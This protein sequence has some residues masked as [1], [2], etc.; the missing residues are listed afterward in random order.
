MAAITPKQMKKAVWLTGITLFL[1]LG[2]FWQLSQATISNPAVQTVT[3]LGTGATTNYTI[4]FPF[5]S[6]DQIR[7][8]LQDESSSPPVRT[9]LAYGS[10]AAKF[11][12]S[13]G[14]PGTTVVMGTAPSTSQRVVITRHTDISQKVHYDPDAAFPSSD[15][16]TNMDKAY[17]IL[18]EED[19]AIGKKVGLST[20]SSATTP[21][22]PDPTADR[23]VMYNHAGT[24]LQLGPSAAAPSAGDVM[25]YA[26]TGWSTTSII[27]TLDSSLSAHI[28]NLN[29]PHQVTAA[30]VGNTSAQWNANKIQGTTVDASGIGD[31]KAL[32]YSSSSGTIVYTTIPGVTGTANYVGAYNSAGSYTPEAQV[33][34]GQGG[35]GTDI[36]SSTGL[37][38]FSSGVL[39]IGTGQVSNSD[40]ASGAAIARSKVATGTAS[41]VV[42]NDG[43]GALSSEASLAASRGGLGTPI[44]GSSTGLVKFTSGAA[45]VATLVD[46]DVASGASVGYTKLNLTG[47]IT[48]SDIN[49]GAAIARSKIVGGT[50][51][52]IVANNTNGALSENAALSA[53]TVVTADS[54][55]QLTGVAPGTSG[56]VLTSTGS[57]W[58]S[59][60]P[61][62]TSIPTR[63]YEISNLGLTA[64][65]SGGAMTVALKQSDTTQNPSTGASAVLIGFSTLTGGYAQRS[66]TGALSMAVSSGASLGHQNG[67]THYLYVYAL[68]NA[69]TVELAVSTKQ[70]DE[71]VLQTTTAMSGAASSAGTLYSTSAR[72]KKAIRLIGRLKVNEPTAGTW[73]V[74]PSEIAISPFDRGEVMSFGQGLAIEYLR[75]SCL[76]GGS[77]ISSKSSEWV[78]S[79]G[80]ATRSSTQCTVTIAGGSFSGTPAC[81]ATVESGTAQAIAVTS[82]SNVQV[83]VFAASAADYAFQLVCIGSK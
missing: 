70:F 7:V 80:V 82:D 24:D 75:A 81:T 5:Q 52:R 79:S 10:G 22:L 8:Y 68:D 63:S 60:A 2:S 50:P 9:L 1:A 45:T 69:G 26:S 39:T 54:N 58:A 57:T 44:G 6:N 29:N 31:A 76:S 74:A 34:M 15:H 56:N 13:G 36:G 48:N 47:N 73:S 3:A 4:G 38:K 37:A 18:L 32:A 23:F 53:N 40:V 42:I 62:S 35:F 33:T 43:T 41:H 14:D 12:I 11:T 16:E 67:I 25:R 83:R 20:A 28:S 71:G 77:T 65:V 46:A 72:T 78:L 55:G 64:T 61:A 59:S 21:V 49:S 27:G 51:F 19:F 30:Q 17:Q 66:V